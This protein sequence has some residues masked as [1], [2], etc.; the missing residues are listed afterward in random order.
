MTVAVFFFSYELNFVILYQFHL[1]H[2]I[3]GCE[4]LN[5]RVTIFTIERRYEAV[6]LRD[7]DKGTYLGNSVSRA[8]KNVNEKISEALIGMD[9]VLQSQIDQAMIDLDK[10]EKKVVF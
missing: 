4:S 10:T 5:Y 1:I 2:F 8:V 6:E 3:K 7:G 9:P